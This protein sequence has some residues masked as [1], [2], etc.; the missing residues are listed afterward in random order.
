MA[1][2]KVLMVADGSPFTFGPQNTSPDMSWFSLSHLVGA[3][4]SCP[5]PTI[6][7]DTAHRRGA[8]FAGSSPST[9]LN[10]TYPGDFTF[11]QAGFDLTRYDELWLMGY[12]GWNYSYPAHPTYS[13]SFSL[14]TQAELAVIAGF[15]AGQG[16]LFAV[17]DHDGL[18]GFMAGY[19][20]RVRTMRKW[21]VFGDPANTAFAPNWNAAGPGTFTGA[22][23]RFDSL[24]RD[25][26][27]QGFYFDGQSDAVPQPTLDANGQPLGTSNL[28]VHPLLRDRNG[29]IIAAWP[30]HMHEGEA[31]G[32]AAVSNSATPFDPNDA[33]GN[34]TPIAFMPAGQPTQSWPEFPSLGGY[35]PEPEVIV[36]GSDLGHVT[37]EAYGPNAAAAPAGSVNPTDPTSTPKTAPASGAG[38][39]KVGGKVSVYDGRGVS[40]GRIVAGA[41]LHH[42]VD[43]NLLGN[44]GTEA[45]YVAPQPTGTSFGLQNAVVDGVNVLDA[46]DDYYRNTAV[47]LARPDPSFGFWTV[48]NTFGADEVENV[49]PAGFVEAFYLAVDGYSPAQLGANPQVTFSGPFAAAGGAQIASAGAPILPDQGAQNTPQLILLPF[50]VQSIPTGTGSAFPQP[51][52][53]PVLLALAAQL[54][55]GGA[56]LYAEA[57]FEL[58]AAADP[59][60]V[61]VAP[62]AANA[63]WLSQDLR[64][65]QLTRDQAS[66]PFGLAFGAG[67]SGYDY[68]AALLATLNADA[69]FTSGAADPFQVLQESGDLTEASSISPTA[70]VGGVMTPACNFA[71]AR[72]RLSGLPSAANT[73]A[74]VR[75]FFRLF[76]TAT[77][78]TDYDPDTSY[79]SDLD[80][81]GLPQ[82]PLPGLF[83]TTFPLYASLDGTGDYGG[84]APLNQ[85]TLEAGAGGVRWAYFGCYLDLYGQPGAPPPLIGAH[86]CLV[87]QIAYDQA[88]ILGASGVTLSPENSDKLAQR[89]IEMVAVTVAP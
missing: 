14:L 38:G 25:V 66:P 84:A 50:T 54:N 73:A 37:I 30:D 43:L 55:L 16:G 5:S 36:W 8:V 74:D 60:F 21:F 53:A 82:S 32:F 62:G 31:T 49:G 39:G 28:S 17:G 51:G 11:T 7:V 65:F 52:D 81:A 46:M 26:N 80:A 9:A 20:P 78:D 87:A 4:T 33:A 85:M 41:S 1:D 23:D 76:T 86:H 40:V 88:P 68:I 89:N 47:W 10:L 79:L 69:G 3:L 71:V 64:V 6:Q 83:G 13:N 22:P 58:T 15:M 27:G 44:P 67:Q 63:F 57:L 61:N 75:V 42:Y 34:P 18:G 19:L 56:S 29:V 24:R 77:N 59:Y 70:L 45:T 48:K 12:E 2:I 35:Q 72:V